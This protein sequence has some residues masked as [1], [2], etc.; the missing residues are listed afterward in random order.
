MPLSSLPYLTCKF[1]AR[2]Y[3][4]EPL[5]WFPSKGASDSLSGSRL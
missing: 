1:I 5:Q 3:D 2:L 4:I